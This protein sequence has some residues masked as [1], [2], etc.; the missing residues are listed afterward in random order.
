MR[1]LAAVILVLALSG[2][3]GGHGDGDG[4]R[5]GGGAPEAGTPVVSPSAGSAGSRA[6]SLS[7]GADEVHLP[8][9]SGRLE[10]AG[11][12]SRLPALARPLDVRGLI[13]SSNDERLY[14]GVVCGP[15]TAEQF[16]TLVARARLTAYEGRPALR[17]TTRTGVR[18]LMWLERPGVAVYVAA[19]PGLT[20]Q[21]R[22]VA[23]GIE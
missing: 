13:W 11:A 21:M 22:R 3:A 6:S 10:R 19:T 2:C 8:A 9:V 16:A 5:D 20:A 18:N 12:F 7:C 1:R 14:A 15:R 17:W 23:A 4:D